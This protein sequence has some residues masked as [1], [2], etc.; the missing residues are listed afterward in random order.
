MFPI[1]E[2]RAQFPILS[3]KVHGKP[4]VYFDN[5]ATT[6][7][8]QPV[9]DALTEAYTTYNA[10]I[11]RGVHHLSQ[12]TTQKYEE[13]RSTVAQYLHVPDRESVIFTSGTTA[14]INLAAN[15]LAE[16]YLKPN[17]AIL[18]SEMEHH[19]NLVS[20][21]LAAKR[22]GLRILK[23]A[24]DDNAQLDLDILPSL[25]ENG[26]RVVAL[27]HIS[28]VTG[29]VN[30]IAQI[31]EIVHRAGALLF[32]DGAQ[33]V[34]HY[35][36]DL[37]ALGADFYA[38]SGHKIYAP[39]GIGV[40]WG[41]R[42][43]LDHFQP[44]MG[45]GEMVGHV[46]FENTTYAQLP[47]RLEAGTPPYV[48][49]IGL[50]AALNFYMQLNEQYPHASLQHETSLLQKAYQGLQ[51]I[52]A[53]VYGYAPTN[54]AILSFNFP[55]VHPYDVGTILDQLGIAL[56]TGTHC[57][58]PFMT[59]FAIPGTVRASFALYN[60]ETEVDAFLNALAR[61]KEMLM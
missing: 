42:E 8:P 31:A 44:W 54:A 26:V 50:A 56:R 59:R 15:A 58:E 55:S 4:L 18:I 20:W 23:W 57:A 34:K 35:P 27:T 22:Y 14:A 61:A 16:S 32:V 33:G 10:N 5:G 53:T 7:K 1:E 38:F 45:G 60:T 49:A 39:N 6:Q 41:R 40:L 29:V 11:H 3:Q 46:A 48:E 19:S 52:G 43:L 51:D 47:F 9:L 21:Q 30:P 12:I 25:L 24:I 2:V 36:I 28:N 17:D 13:A 37:P